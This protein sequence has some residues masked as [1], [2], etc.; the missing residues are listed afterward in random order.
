MRK[1]FN[2]TAFL[3]IY[4][5]IFG[6]LSIVNFFLSIATG[7]SFFKSFFLLTLLCFPVTLAL[8]FFLNQMSTS[9]INGLYGLGTKEDNVAK[10]CNSEVM[11]LITLKEDEEYEAVLNGLKTIEEK[12]GV[13]SRIIY[14]RAQ[15]LMELGQFRKARRCVK[16]FLSSTP[17]DEHD[18]YQRYCRELIT[19][20]HA[21]L[22][23]EKINS[24]E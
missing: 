22:T 11:K 3:R 2:S 8:M 23:L 24:N 18:S 19:H 21:P 9:I 4:I 5:S 20:E 12:Y 7:T 14:E 15:C 16:D 10:I 1:T 13:S 6:A 17:P